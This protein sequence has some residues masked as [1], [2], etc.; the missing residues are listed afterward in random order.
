MPKYVGQENVSGSRADDEIAGVVLRRDGAKPREDRTSSWIER[1]IAASRV[2]AE[3]PL[4][5]FAWQR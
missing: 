5:R 1:L 3:S 2:H 4:G